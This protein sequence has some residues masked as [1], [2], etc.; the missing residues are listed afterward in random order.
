MNLEGKRPFRLDSRPPTKDFA[1]IALREA[2]YAVLAKA[3][4]EGH[5]QLMEEAVQDIADRWLLYEEFTE[6]DRIAIDEEEAE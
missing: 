6:L 3:N 5:E 1:E 4:P 2:R